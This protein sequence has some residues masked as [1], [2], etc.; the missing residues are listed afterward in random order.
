VVRTKLG[1]EGIPRALGIA[2]RLV[3]PLVSRPVPEGAMAQCWAAVH[4]DAAAFQGA[5]LVDGRQRAP[6][7]DADDPELAERLW[8]RTEQIVLA[9]S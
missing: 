6:R 1:R 3:D 7:R 5:Y 8:Q 2:L 9:L 4:P